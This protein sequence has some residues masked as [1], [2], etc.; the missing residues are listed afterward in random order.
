M[1]TALFLMLPYPSHVIAA[2]PYA[3]FLQQMGVKVIF[4]NTL[5]C[6]NL[7]EKN[8]FLYRE[9]TFLRE[10]KIKSVG[11]FLYLFLQN[12][13]GNVITI[14]R[15]REYLGISREI[16][17]LTSEF[18]NP[19]VYIDQQI[20][21]YY[22]FFSSKV[23]EVTLINTRLSSKKVKA[24]PP[25]SSKFVPNKSIISSLYCELLW[26]IQLAN[27]KVNRLIECAAFLGKTDL[28]I[29]GRINEIST[30]G[31]ISR[32]DFNRSF[33]LGIAGIKEVILCPKEIEFSWRSDCSSEI[34]F[35]DTFKK[36]ESLYYT[37]GYEKLLYEIIKFK[38][39]INSSAIICCSFGT[40]S[41]MKW[42]EINVLIE[43]LSFV[44]RTKR[45]WLF[46]VSS[47][48]LPL[49][50]I[51]TDRFK[52]IEFLPLQSFLS[53]ADIMISHGGLGTIKDCWEARVPMYIL[54]MNQKSDNYGN[55][56]RVE[57]SGFGVT[58]NLKKVNSKELESKITQ[59]INLIP[60]FR[61]S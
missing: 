11:R 32:I 51:Q 31:M 21:E 41:G 46:V 39:Q 38:S 7:I 18:K 54:P 26:L 17:L 43:K 35:G 23:K 15:L 36:D 34:Y 48:G 29:L 10:F 3:H 8:G 4:L 22:F 5:N 56:A 25:L 33:G 52:I 40:L 59:A 9:I 53:Y 45:D 12:T 57:S 14:E 44:S 42:K 49:N 37:I 50:I 27:R 19:S 30:E 16:N 28:R 1:N 55:A 58:S 61:K 20:A 2:F 13:L 60:D 24:M 6:K 47:G